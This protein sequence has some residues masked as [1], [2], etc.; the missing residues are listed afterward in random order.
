MGKKIECFVWICQRFSQNIRSIS[1]GTTL[2]V[3]TVVVKIRGIFLIIFLKN[4]RLNR[5]QMNFF[6]IFDF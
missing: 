2:M 1:A 3:H 5:R 6:E 4:V